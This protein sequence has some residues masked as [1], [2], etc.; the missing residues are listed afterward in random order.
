A[1]VVGWV[2][3]TGRSVTGAMG[4]AR[5]PRLGAGH[6]GLA[7]GSR[8]WAMAVKS[9]A[10]AAGGRPAM[11]PPSMARSWPVT[12]DEASLASH[13]TAAATSAGTPVRPIGRGG[14]RPAPDARSRRGRG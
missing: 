9:A 2:R 1:V 11:I 7:L 4:G 13:S 6:G 10:E 14:P 12:N 8:A 5:R 3:W